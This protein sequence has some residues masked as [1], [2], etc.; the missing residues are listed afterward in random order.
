MPVYDLDKLMEE[1]RRVAAEF[2]S[3]VGE[4]LPVTPEIAKYDAVRILGLR[5]PEEDQVGYDALM[6]DDAGSEIP[7]IIKGRV[8]FDESRSG[9]RLGSLNTDAPWQR[10]LLVLLDADY[11]TREIY[12]LDR[13]EALEAGIDLANPRGAMTIAKFRAIGRCL[14]DRWNGPVESEILDNR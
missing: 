2:R 11:T 12:A 14:W 9:H 6:N 7:C 3:T 1:T 4:T 13:D 8:I 5:K 10:I